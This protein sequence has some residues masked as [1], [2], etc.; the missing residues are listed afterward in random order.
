VRSSRLFVLG[1][2]PFLVIGCGADAPSPVAPP[3]PAPVASASASAPPVTAAP[4]ADASPN[5]RTPAQLER[6][7]ALAPS[8]LSILS[9]FG[10][11]DAV[12]SPDGKKIVFRS[13]RGGL[14][15][16]FVAR[17][18]QPREPPTKVIGG[19]ERVETVAWSRD[20]KYLV[21]SRDVGADEN[22]RLFR[23]SPDGSNVVELTPGEKLHRDAP[24]LPRKA[25]D[26]VVYSARKTTSPETRVFVQK[27]S[28]GEPRVAL[29]D[30]GPSF[31]VDVSPDGKR[32]LLERF[33]SPSDQSLFEADLS[34]GK[35]TPVF[36]PA[37]KAVGISA[38]AYSADG[39][40]VFVAS[41]G[42]GE[43]TTLVSLEARTLAEKARFTIADPAFARATSLEVSP[44]GDA[45]ALT[46]DAGNRNDV[47]LLD[48]RTLKERAKVG[49]PLGD[50]YSGPF[51][52]D[53][54]RLVVLESRADS[55]TDLLIAD[56]TTGVTKKLRD[57]R[58]PGL[59]EMPALTTDIVSI[60]A[61]DGLSLPMN[62]YLPA[63]LPAGKKLRTIVSF[64]GGPA[65]SSTVGWSFMTRFFTSQGFAVVEPNMR[66]STGFGRAYERADNREKRADVLK[67]MATINAWVKSQAWCDAERVAIFG[68]S[69][70]GYVV[71]MG[72]T[73]QPEL[74]RAGVDLVGIANLET[75]LASTDQAI[76]SAFVDEFGDLEKDAAL[77]K[78]FSPIRDV[79]KVRAPLFVYQGENDPRVPK[80]ESELIVKSLRSRGVPVEY[81]VAKDEGH[82]VDR[83]ETRVEFLT[84]VVRFLSDEMK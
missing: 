17:I 76:R 7:Q 14:P 21:F 62:V 69:Y 49:G 63:S 11:F 81:M 37:G 22:F 10:N 82:S 75:F 61:H 32:A 31:V 38:A 35:L 78:Q 52:A 29:T 5:E 57:D 58:R 36:P 73:R 46:V 2:T 9:A 40:R 43:T 15:E 20:G 68:G 4:T 77:L 56:A 47:R 71:L 19:P 1:L 30:S 70:G 60:K 6:D 74:W 13:S 48:A 42:G 53:G 59:S 67:D 8:V 45:V 66:G 23:A 12:P 27:L 33:T 39:A 51:T 79:D 41:D 80:T 26:L 25:P 24:L 34:T 54:R 65:S 3:P 72:L 28:G 55:P 83:K 64:H 18:D 50:R 44:T 84:R 16:A